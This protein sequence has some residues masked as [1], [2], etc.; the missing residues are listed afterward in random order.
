MKISKRQLALILSFVLVVGVFFGAKQLLAD[1]GN[2]GY[3]YGWSSNIGWIKLNNC[4]DPANQGTCT[5]SSYGV[6]VMP[7]APGTISGYAWSSNIGWITFNDSGCPTPGCTPGARANWTNKNSDGSVNITGW[8]RACSVYS[9]GCSGALLGQDALGGWDGYIALDSSTG[10][11]SGGQWGLKINND[12][13]VQGFAWGSDVI[14]W[15]KGITMAIS[16]A[17]TNVT[18]TA[19]PTSIPRGN[20]STL[21]VT[22]TNIDGPNAC[23]GLPSPVTM[24]LGANNTWTGTISVSPLTTTNYTVNCTKG[25][26]TGTA[27]ATVTVTF[28][29]TPGG[30]GGG[31]GTGGYCAVSAPQFAWN[32][33][34]S[35]CTITRQGGGSQTVAGTSQAAGGALGTD[36]NYYFTSS[37]SLTGGSS[38][39]YTLQCGSGSTTLTLNTTVNRCVPDYTVTATPQT[40]TLVQSDKQLT[41][42]YTVS[43]VPRDGFSAPIDLTIAAWP[44]TMPASKNFTFSPATV[45]AS[46]GSYGTSTLT[47]TIDAADVKTSRTFSPIVIQ[48][49]GSGIVRQAS[50]GAGAVVKAQPI[51]NEF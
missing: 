44:S 36:G 32:S 9:N 51:Y 16:G 15:I 33:A 49:T 11:G 34:A 30:S 35:S 48:G 10:G 19:N 43:I 26:Y 21:T 12:S 42:T 3:G 7:T 29:T 20:S 13:T 23:S 18:L 28:F 47:I 25:T 27:N 2:N 24:V 39:T 50:I 46:N 4:D 1:A 45:T 41:A 38:T 6:S 31:S 17:G 8:A 22:A 40:Q 14:G 37:L 5:G